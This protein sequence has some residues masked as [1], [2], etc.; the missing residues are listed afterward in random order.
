MTIAFGT[1]SETL[2]RLEGQLTEACVLPQI[3]FTVEEW[4]RNSSSILDAIRDKGWNDISLIIRSSAIAEDTNAASMAGHYLTIP[5]VLGPAKISEAILKVASSY[6]SNRECEQIFIQPMLE[7]VA[8]S[9]VAFSVD[10]NSGSPYIIINYDD[11]TGS[12]STVTS[13]SGIRTKSY[14]FCKYSNAKQRLDMEPVIHLVRKLETLL[15]NPAIDIEFAITK[16]SKVYLLQVRPLTIGPSSSVSEMKHRQTLEELEKKFEALNRPHPYLHG[17]RTVFGV[18]PDWNPAEII[19]IRPRPLALSLY[20]ELVTD[21]IWAYQRDNYGYKN[22]RS[23]PLMVGFAGLPYI[24][25]RVSFNSFIPKG[26]NDELAEKI[27][28]YYIGK[29]CEYPSHHDKVEFEVVYTCYT[30]DLP[31]RVADL[32]ENGFSQAE[33][34]ELAENLRH[35]TNGIIHGESGFWRKDIDKVNELELRRKTIVDSSLDK[36]S[37]IYWLMEDCKRYGTLPFAGLARAGFIAVQLLKSLIHVGILSKKDYADFMGS[38]DTVSSRMARDKKK[39]N[40]DQFLSEYGHLRPGTYDILSSR[41]D[42]DPDRYFDWNEQPEKA[43]ESGDVFVLSMKQLKETEELLKKHQ[44]QHDVIGLFDFIKDAIEGREQAKF[45]FSRSLSDAISLIKELGAEYGL[46]PEDSSLMNYSCIQELYASST[47][48]SKTLNHSIQEGRECYEIAQHVTLPPVITS[49]EEVWSFQI[50]HWEP[51]F[52]TL[53]KAEG[54]VVMADDS[55]KEMEGAILFIPNADPGYDWIFLRGIVA[56]VTMYGGANSHMAIRA[57]ELGMPAVIG[58][59]NE[60]FSSWAKARLLEVDCSNKQVH[61]L[62]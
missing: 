5:N 56:F 49:P 51:N 21:N 47:D 32:K 59:G 44:L 28:N 11:S 57:G 6:N 50:P 39:L 41:Y 30:L 15:V 55:E 16:D 52:I 2:E 37:K 36:I 26:V 12:T 4:N 14:Y 48:I 40:R 9:G 3:R 31:E 25:V 24:D 19:G 46:S 45:I 1:K 62:K 27:V 10:P 58:A 7:N 29:L 54:N 61:I 38:L 60:L 20:K 18:M 13:G 23:F 22:L 33:C 43:Q 53:E 35:L 17:S 8:M 42:E 34:D